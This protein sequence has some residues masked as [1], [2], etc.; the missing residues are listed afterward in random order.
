MK[1]ALILFTVA[2]LGLSVQA[3]E[4]PTAFHDDFTKGSSNWRFS[5]PKAWKII[6]F[7]GGKALS[8]FDKK[9]GFKP[10]QRS[11]FHF[12]LVK[13]LKVEDFVLD[14]RLRS[15]VKDYG[16]RDLCL[17]FGYQDNSH[18]YYVHLGKKTDDHA[19]QIFIVKGADRKKISTKTTPGTNWDDNWHQVRVRRDAASGSI[20]VFF[21]D[22][23]TPVMTAN[24]KAFTWGTV[25]VGSFDDTGDWSAIKLLGKKRE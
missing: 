25:G 12:A 8:Q 2:V 21:D 6:D 5:D 4:L 16:H 18:F 11:P 9:S 23:K 10:P 13:D 22:M 19:N 3:G 20:E 17:F 24:D 7:E 1:K 14:A 15:T